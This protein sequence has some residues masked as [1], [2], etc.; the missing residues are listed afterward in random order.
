M[1]KAA[2]N[3]KPFRLGASLAVQIVFLPNFITDLTGFDFVHFPTLSSYVLTKVLIW[4]VL[5]ALI[6]GCLFHLFQRKDYLVWLVVCLATAGVFSYA[7]L[8]LLHCIG[9]GVILTLAWRYTASILEDL[10]IPVVAG[11]LIVLGVMATRQYW[12]LPG[13]LNDVVTLA[14]GKSPIPPNQPKLSL[15]RNTYL[16]VFDEFS[17]NSLYHAGTISDRFPNFKRLQQSSVVPQI[18]TTNYDYTYQAIPAIL[19][20]RYQ[21]PAN[22]LPLI[23]LMGQPNLFDRIAPEQVMVWGTFIR[24]CDS[25][26]YKGISSYCLD[27]HQQYKDKGLFALLVGDAAVAFHV[28]IAQFPLRLLVRAL[29]SLNE[30]VPITNP[31]SSSLHSLLA[32][33]LSASNNWF[34]LGLVSHQQTYF[35]MEVERLQDFLEKI[36][37]QQNTL[38]YYHSATPHNPFLYDRDFQMHKDFEFSRF[39]DTENQSD[40]DRV[41]VQYLRS[42]EAADQLLGMVLDRIEATDP[43]AIILVTADHGALRTFGLAPTRGRGIIHPDVAEIPF[44]LSLPPDLQQPIPSPIPW[45]QHVD[46]LPTLLDLW[47]YPPDS[48]LPGV[49]LLSGKTSPFRYMSNT[50]LFTEYP[51][52]AEGD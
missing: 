46:I 34:H 5:P 48:S 45:S 12:I 31:S 49:S 26:R 14:L 43:T 40:M 16:M 25:L 41:N 17:A 19:S 2:Q 47:G 44:F 35:P 11:A 30:V 3:K 15:L 51:F 18:S 29:T 20:G 39:E 10:C 32:S 36:G 22:I 38:Y 24:Y 9:I 6:L 7:K 23:R 37:S 13:P 42:I 1:H 27:L 28:H 4:G 50:Q 33:L 21:D 52:L 8:P